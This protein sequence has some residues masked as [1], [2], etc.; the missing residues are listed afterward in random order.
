LQKGNPMMY[1]LPNGKVIHLTVEQYLDL[2]DNDMQYLMSMNAGE[3][4]NSPF[5][6]SVLRSSKKQKEE[7]VEEDRSIDYLP[8]TEEPFNGQNIDSLN[9]EYPDFPEDMTAV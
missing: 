4:T 9:E 5:T 3:Y 2:T 1:Q 8:E 7:E 6:G